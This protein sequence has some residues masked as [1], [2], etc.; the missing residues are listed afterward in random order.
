MKTL[1]DLRNAV[2]EAELVLVG[3]GEEFET[4]WDR[5]RQ[6]EPY[7]EWIREIEEKDGMGW[8]LQ[9][10][11]AD[12]LRQ[13]K[14][15]ETE[16]AYAG[17]YKLLE[18]KNYFLV[19]LCT[20]GKLDEFAWKENR[21]VSPCGGY[22]RMQCRGCQGMLV[23]A[24]PYVDEVIHQ[25]EI[26]QGKLEQVK[27]PVCS[28]C[29]EPLAFNNIFAENYDEQG[30]LPMW[31]IYMKWLQGTMNRNV[32]VIELGVGMKFPSVIRWPFEKLAFFNQ[33]A[34]FFRIHSRLYQMSEELKGKGVSIAE[35][36]IVF[37]RN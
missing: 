5:M 11:R 13:Y 27:C 1:D 4:D 29:G 31:D 36:P 28:E 35:N 12:Y 30:Y 6:T 16:E 20:D 14:E 10:L 17:L 21:I 15:K 24:I 19:S 9:Y 3:I 8:L 2:A 18:G 23:D 34:S 32:C 7:A 26:N 25:C 33:K 22:T 37:L